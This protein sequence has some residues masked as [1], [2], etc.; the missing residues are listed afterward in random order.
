ML[1]RAYTGQPQLLL[2]AVWQMFHVRDGIV[3]LVRNPFPG[4][5]GVNAGPTFEVDGATP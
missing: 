2:E 5:D 4:R 1:T 3:R